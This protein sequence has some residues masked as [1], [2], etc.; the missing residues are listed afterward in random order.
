MATVTVTPEAV[1]QAAELP[2]AIRGRLLTALA[3]Y[4]D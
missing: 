3:V 1:E 2:K 4:E